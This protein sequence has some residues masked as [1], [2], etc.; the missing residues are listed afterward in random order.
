[1]E[2]REQKRESGQIAKKDNKDLLGFA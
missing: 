1:M 2:T